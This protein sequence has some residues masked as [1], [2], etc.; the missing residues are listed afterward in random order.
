MK[1]AEK[2][3]EILAKALELMAEKG[4][5]GVPMSLL[6]ETAGVAAGTIYLYFPSKD[7][8]IDEVYREVERRITAF[9]QERNIAGRPVRERF[10]GTMKGLLQYFIAN[11]L[12]FRYVE[13]YFNSPYGIS[14]RRDKISRWRDKASAAPD[15]PDMLA[16]L[17]EEGIAAHVVKDLPL[18][19]LYCLAVAPLVFL[20]RDHILGFVD[21]DEGLIERTTE[22]CW[23][24]VRC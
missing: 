12:E 16:D 6:A 23:D 21:L 18:I 5:H 13:Q 14:V 10:L 3:D 7:A 1:S 17:F 4:F 9:L 20:A 8:L 19:V 24:A 22:A 15:Q 2:R 11:S